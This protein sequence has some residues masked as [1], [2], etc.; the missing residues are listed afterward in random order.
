MSLAELR[1]FAL[2]ELGWSIDR[3]RYATLGEFNLAARGYW[4]NWERNTGWLMREVVYS[5][6]AGNPYINKVDKP[7]SSKDI[8]KISD[9]KEV[10][11]IE[12]K[13]PTAEELEAIKNVL[14]NGI[15]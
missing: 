6:V 5:M 12:P 13:P 4:R 7:K 9:D 2:G 1:E 3:W 15:L 8:L 11:K 14:S 10:K